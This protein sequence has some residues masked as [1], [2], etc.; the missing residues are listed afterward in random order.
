[1]VAI[2]MW[3]LAATAVSVSAYGEYKVGEKVRIA[4]V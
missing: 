3:L 1:M 2:R 4:N